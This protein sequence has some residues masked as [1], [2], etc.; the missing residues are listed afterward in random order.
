MTEADQ[1]KIFHQWLSGYRALLSKIVRAYAHNTEDMDDL[2]QEITV[3]IWRSIPRF[4]Y[5]SAVSTWLYRI[6]LNTAIRWTGSERKHR[7]GRTEINNEIYILKEKTK[8]EDDR[9]EWLYSEIKQMNEIDKS[10]A[11]LLLDGF[12]YREMAEIVGITET[13]IGVKI[14]R[15]KKHLITRSEK[16]EVR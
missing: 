5:E 1:L 9:L 13:N 2:F 4:R 14:H 6:S 10:L 11:L 8:D 3:Q 15:I 7:D 12:S 16:F